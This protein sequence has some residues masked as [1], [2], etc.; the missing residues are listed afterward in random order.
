MTSSGAVVYKLFWVA[1]QLEVFDST[2][3]H[4]E[5]LHQT[6]IAVRLPCRLKNFL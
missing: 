2:V 4:L 1:A 5:L 6:Y 3:A